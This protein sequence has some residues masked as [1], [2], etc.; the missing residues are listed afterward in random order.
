M[1]LLV[2]LGIHVASREPV[3]NE[4]RL[5][6]G[7]PVRQVLDLLTPP[8]GIAG[9]AD[10]KPFEIPG[11]PTRY[12]VVSIADGKIAIGWSADPAIAPATSAYVPTT[13]SF[14]KSWVAKEDNH[15]V[16]VKASTSIASDVSVTAIELR[17]QQ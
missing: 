17:L 7:S 8:T 6:T 13:G 2:W 4:P 14:V 1:L 15:L 11:D 3:E 5:I 16:V 9:T 12:L 10:T